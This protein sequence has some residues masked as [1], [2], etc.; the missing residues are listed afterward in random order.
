M[1]KLSH[2][3]R[4]IIAGP[5]IVAGVSVGAYLIPQAMAPTG[6]WPTSPPSTSLTIAAARWSFTCS[7][8]ATPTCPW[9]PSRP[10]R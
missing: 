3:L 9:D 8:D 10:S 6:P 4:E 2:Q 5:N 1:G 7:F